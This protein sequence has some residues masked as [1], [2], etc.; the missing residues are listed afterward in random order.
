MKVRCNHCME[1]FDED[2]IIFDEKADKELCPK[3]NRSGGLMDMEE[4]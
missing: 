1:I 2:E 4:Q 3:C